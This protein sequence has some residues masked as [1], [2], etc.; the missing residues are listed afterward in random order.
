MHN[1]EDNYQEDECD[2][3]KEETK[4]TSYFPAQEEPPERAINLIVYDQQR[5][6]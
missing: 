3:L 5:G 4:Q 6:K 2:G 1:E